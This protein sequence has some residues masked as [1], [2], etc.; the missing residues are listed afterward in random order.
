M[1]DGRAQV[2]VATDVAA[3]GL[4][5]PDLGLVLHAQLPANRAGL[6]HRSGRTGRAGRKGTSVLL[7]PYNRRRQVEA[8]L[9]SANITATWGEPP[10]A[11]SIRARDQERLLDDPIFVEPPSD[12]ELVLARAIVGNRTAEQVA[13]ALLR[14]HRSGVRAG[15]SRSCSTRGRRPGARMIAAAVANRAGRGKGPGRR[16][17]SAGRRPARA[18]CR[19]FV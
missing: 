14:L 2:C 18:K 1:R 3:R 12:D 17:A 8:M 11:D 6:L 4:D 9:A 10:S 5:L 13:T 19:G 16:A 15:Y 7:V